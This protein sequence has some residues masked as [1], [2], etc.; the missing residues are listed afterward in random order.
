MRFPG[1]PGEEHHKKHYGNASYDD[2][3]DRWQAK[4]FKADE[5]VKVFA[6]AGARYVIPVTKHHVSCHR[7]LPLKCLLEKKC[8]SSQIKDGIT[9]WD[10]PGT[11][12]RNTVH[13]G[14]RRDLVDEFAKACDEEGLKFGVYYST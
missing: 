1:G 13:R 11:G 7:V 6:K 10:A 5:M 3:L 9:L 8:D 12:T 14:P 2:F 4:D